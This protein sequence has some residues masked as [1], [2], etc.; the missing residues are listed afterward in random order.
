MKY[1]I[2]KTNKNSTIYNEGFKISPAHHL[3]QK[4]DNGLKTLFFKKIGDKA[5]S[6]KQIRKNI[7]DVLI[8]N[9]WKLINKK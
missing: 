8:K 9:G 4:K 5:S 3:V 1:K 7:I 6:R 2:I